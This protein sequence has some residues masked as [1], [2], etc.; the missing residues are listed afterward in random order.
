MRILAIDTA[1]SA[2][3]ACIMDAGAEVPLAIEQIAMERGHAEALMPM[4][5]RLTGP[6]TGTTQQPGFGTLD[7]VAVT[8]GP[9]SYTGLRVGISAARAI[10]LAANIPVVGITSLAAL[11]APLIG[12]ETGRLLVAA[13]DA[14]H[15]HVYVCVMTGS[16][17]AIVAPRLV[18]AKDA[19]RAIGAGPASLTGSGAALVAQE[20]W[21]MGLDVVVLDGTSAPD[22]RFVA[23]LGLLADP[24]GSAPRPLYLRAPV[25]TSQEH[26]RIARQ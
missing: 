13:I 16:G 26:A 22:I 4:L 5:E 24:A 19:A 12:R 17:R 11:A 8:I 14:R 20:A 23:R 2:C 1:L 9:G 18:N 6:G 10:G 7:R 21:A 15:G 3:S 25:A